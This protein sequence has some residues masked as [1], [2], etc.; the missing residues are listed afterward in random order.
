MNL[1]DASRAIHVLHSQVALHEAHA[2][3]LL[4]ALPH[5][6]P[7]V[8]HRVLPRARDR[9]GGDDSRWREG[10]DAYWEANCDGTV[11]RQR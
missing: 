4:H 5:G 6:L 1:Q 7:H 2:I 10:E 11:C 9:R 3:L 8:L